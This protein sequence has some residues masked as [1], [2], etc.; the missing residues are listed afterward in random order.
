MKDLNA[1]ANDKSIIATN[2]TLV[3]HAPEQNIVTWN[4]SFPKLTNVTF[5]GIIEALFSTF[6][7]FCSVLTFSHMP[8][9]YIYLALFQEVSINKDGRAL[10]DYDDPGSTTKCN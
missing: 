7:P 4:L 8:G 2:H 5:S 3:T 6:S 1:K 9:S 10:C